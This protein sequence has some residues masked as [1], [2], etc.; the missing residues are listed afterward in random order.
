MSSSGMTQLSLGLIDTLTKLELGKKE[1]NEE[2]AILLN[3]YTLLLKSMSI[4]LE[5]IENGKNETV[6]VAHKNQELK[7]N[8]HYI[9]SLTLGL[10]LNRPC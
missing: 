3:S 8:L 1:I 10:S 2:Y 6:R 9:K 4:M 5:K 7:N